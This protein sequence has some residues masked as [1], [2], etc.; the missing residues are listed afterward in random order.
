MYDLTMKVAAMQ[1]QE[2]NRVTLEAAQTVAD[3]VTS[4]A[5]RRISASSTEAT[6][7]K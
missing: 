5:A 6:L 7:D 1:A 4:T 2:N 3:A